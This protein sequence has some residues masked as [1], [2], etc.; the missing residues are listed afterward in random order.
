VTDVMPEVRVVD[1]GA[2]EGQPHAT[3]APVADAAHRTTEIRPFSLRFTDP[4]REASF[5]ASYFRDNIRF[6]RLAHVLGIAAWAMFGLMAS[7]VLDEG[8]R[9]DLMLRFGVAIPIALVALALS[10]MRWYPRRW[11]AV[12]ALGIVI[13]GFVWSFH[14]VVVEDATPGWAY[15]GIMI[16][17]IYLYTLSRLRFAP[18]V[19]VGIVVIAFHNVIAIGVMHDPAEELYLANFFVV[20]TAFMGTAAAYGLE[21]FTRLVYLREQQLDAERDR[22]D[23]LLGNTLPMAIVRRLKAVDSSPHEAILAEQLTDVTVLFADLVDSTSHEGVMTAD[24]LVAT[25]DDVF[26]RFDLLAS[27]LGLEKIKTVGDAYMVVAGAPE[28]IE[29]HVQAAAEMALGMLGSMIGAEWPT[30]DP[31]QL[32]IGVATGPVVAGVIGRDRYAYDLWGDTVNLASRLEASSEPGR[33]LVSTETYERLKDRY[34][35]SDSHVVFLKGKGPTP[36][37]FL[38]GRSGRALGSLT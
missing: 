35:F 13:S 6:I 21:R 25:L 16:V 28:P 20:L 22:A 34:R 36:A 29:D 33:I 18:A 37:R 5:R 27:R 1:A 26:T 24:A 14:R 17:L 19:I 10:W 4:A 30:G 3:T 23:E 7:L 31:M 32:R 15:A 2:A 11:E 38:L 8:Q 12:T 9:T